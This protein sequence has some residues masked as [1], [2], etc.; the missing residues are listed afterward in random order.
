PQVGK[1]HHRRRR[2][3]ECDRHADRQQQHENPEQQRDPHQ[4]SPP[5]CLVQVAMPRASANTTISAPPIASGRYGRLR[6]SG[7]PANFTSK[8]STSSTQP[9]PASTAPIATITRL[10][11]VSTIRRCSGRIAC[12]SRKKPKWRPVC[13]PEAAPKLIAAASSTMVTGSVQLGES[14]TT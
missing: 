9:Q 4:P 14:L 2:Q 8:P 12:A 3:R 5:S 10:T 1:R 11:T 13:T 6:G 7:A